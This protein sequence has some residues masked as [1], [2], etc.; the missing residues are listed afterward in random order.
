MKGFEELADTVL[1]ERP[2]LL[3]AVCSGDHAVCQR[4][5]PP[6]TVGRLSTIDRHSTG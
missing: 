2:V 1:R 4:A 3:H 6:R 5:L